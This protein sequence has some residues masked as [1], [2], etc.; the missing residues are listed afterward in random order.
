[1]SSGGASRTVAVLGHYHGR[2]LG[3]DL[4]VETI[5]A[6]ARSRI[7]DVKLVGISLAPWDTAERHRVRAVPIQPVAAPRRN[8]GS[9]V[10]A[11][12]SG[13]SPL[14]SQLRRV[15]GA[16]PA[17][18]ALAS[19]GRLVREVPFAVRAHRLLRGVDTVVVAGSGQLLDAREG[20]WHHPY[21]IFRWAMLSRLSGTRFVIPS[22]GAGPIYTRLGKLMIVRSV[23]A[24][25]YVSMRDAHSA[26]LLHSIGVERDLPVRPDM[27][28]GY[29]LPNGTPAARNE[30]IRVGVNVMAHRDPRYGSY[31]DVRSFNAYLGK[32]VEFV[33]QLVESG[34][35]VVLFSSQTSIDPLVADDL[36]VA[37]KARGLAEHSR[38]HNALDRIADSDDLVRTIKECDY[39]VAARYHAIL[40]ALALGIPT[41]GLSYH[42]K[43]PDLFA[44]A[45]HSEWCLDI[46]DF[47]PQDLLATLGSVRASDSDEIRTALRAKAADLRAAVERQFD[48]I[49]ARRGGTGS[50]PAGG[51]AEARSR[52]RCARTRRACS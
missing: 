27:G 3:D 47:T 52:A 15:P 44:Q 34:D 30:P 51:R 13:S 48:E 24:A 49:R 21:A 46:D 9:S 40:L 1:M 11:E 26:E 20:P 41:I 25:D 36:L 43:T 45:G 33:A 23:A 19:A 17:R 38:L 50:R 8:G 39:V 22:I 2:N 6:A 16:L 7:P 35:E 28:Y 42:P 29:A 18:R 10:E 37:L 4:V 12:P 14:R 5:M 32:M 31:G